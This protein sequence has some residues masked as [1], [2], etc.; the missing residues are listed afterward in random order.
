MRTLLIL[1]LLLLIAAAVLLGPSAYAFY[2]SQGPL[3]GGVTLGG[4]QPEGETPEDVARSLY[5]R[6]QQPVA[7]YYDSQRI[8]LRPGDVDFQV[9][10]NGMVA[11]AVPFGQGIGFWR[12]FLREVFDQPA[13]PVEIA[14]KASYDEQKLADWLGQVAAE[15]DTAPRPPYGVALA[16]GTPFTSTFMF[17]AGQPGLQLE[18]TLSAQRVV[19]ALSSPT[20][21]QAHL[22]LVEVPPPAPTI[23]ELEKL[24][25]ART[26]RF[27]GFVSVFIRPVNGNE[28][29]SIDPEVAF[30][31][32]SVMK[33]PIMMEL[34][35]SVLDQPPDVETT[36]LL[37]ST[38]GLSGNF[39]AN[40]LLRLIG[41]GEIGNEWQGATR[42]TETLQGLGL[43]N[44]F[45]ATPYD[46]ERMLR[47][48]TT[49]ANSRT[50]YNTQPDSHMQTTAKDIALILEWIVQCSEGGGTLLAALPEQLTPDECSQ[51]LEFMALNRK[52]ILL[53]TGVPEGTRYVHKHG[54]VDDS[55]GDVAAFWSP[56]GPYIVSLFIYKP[57]WVEWELSSSI[58]ADVSKAAWDYFTLVANGGQPPE[59]DTPLPQ[60]GSA[61]TATLPVTQPPP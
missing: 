39:T 2:Q 52:H 27:P 41:G 20:E 18:P 56:A 31:G 36:K 61:I 55:H 23:E 25:I 53:E 48:Y 7:V 40:L 26:D 19:E 42:V 49:P 34:Y 15:H 13:R 6:F 4:M 11:E 50:D 54:F 33:I 57:G 51:M 9:D 21:R 46:T 29:V 32:M 10:V 17:Q 45:M 16:P 47:T 22:V 14:L 1:L 35:R 58:M 28:E 43:Q 37:T 38:M 30:A 3:P 60:A 8:I 24:L 44:T 12:P 5:D 59:I